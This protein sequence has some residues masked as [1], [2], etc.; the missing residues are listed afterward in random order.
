MVEPRIEVDETRMTAET[1][2]LN[3]HIL[4]RK[5]P[6]Q[7]TEYVSVKIVAEPSVQSFLG[8]GAM[9]R[10][11]LPMAMP[12]AAGALAPLAQGLSLWTGLMQAAW[13]PWFQM[14][15]PFLPPPPDQGQGSK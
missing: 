10:L 14:M 7:N 15:A 5:F 9:P 13:R 6:D 11:P 4:R 12:L 8:L 2:S 1:P 3:V